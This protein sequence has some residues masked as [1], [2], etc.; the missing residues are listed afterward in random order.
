MAKIWFG[1]PGDRTLRGD[2]VAERTV[3]W[4]MRELGLSKQHWKCILR[5]PSSFPKTQ[6][7]FDGC[8]E[9]IAVVI[10]VERPDLIGFP[11]WKTGYYIPP[12]HPEAL[13]MMLHDG[14]AQVGRIEA[15]SI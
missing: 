13:R 5:A 15:C 6:F 11:D 1:Y 14:T 2:P 8:Q 7:T 3:Q 12:L 9:P 10:A 4:C